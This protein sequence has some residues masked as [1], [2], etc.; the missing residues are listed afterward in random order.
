MPPASK[1]GAVPSA[2][3]VE[4]L[5]SADVGADVEPFLK[6][7]EDLAHESA[8]PFHSVSWLRSWY[9]TLGACEGRRPVLVGVRRRGSDADVMLLALSCQRTF[10]LSIVEFADATVVD[11]NLPLL[12]PDWAGIDDAGPRAHA[13]WQTVRQALA[14]DHDV[15][16]LHKLA[17]RTLD[18]ALPTVNPLLLALPGRPCEMF[19]TQVHVTPPWDDWLRTL[20]R[21]VRKEFERSWRVFTRSPLARFERITDPTLALAAFEQ[22]EAQQSQRMRAAGKP[23]KLDE[24]AYRAFYRQVLSGGLADGSAVVTALRDGETW[25][26]VHFGVANRHRYI[27]LRISNIGGA[28]QHCS[29]GRLGLER[30]GRHLRQQGLFWIDLGIGDYQYKHA[31]RGTRVPLFDVCEALSWRGLPW[32]WAWRLRQWFKHKASSPD[33]AR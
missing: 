33:T 20:D 2:P 32:V 15:L 25:V 26:S 24:P 16:R 28:W 29:P 21:H 12:A 19:G 31:F 13:I 9:D 23:Y 3:C 14:R 11:Y 30:T 8:S 27:A 6:R 5:Y 17:D 7:W 4:P 22:L 1:H 10:G 18:D